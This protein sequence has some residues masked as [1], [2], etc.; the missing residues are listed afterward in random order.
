LA[1]RSGLWALAQTT[2]VEEAEPAFMPSEVTPDE[3]HAELRRR[4]ALLN[5][6]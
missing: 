5:G 1:C 6:S 2:L 3:I 4:L